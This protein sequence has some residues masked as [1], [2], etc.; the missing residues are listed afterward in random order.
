MYIPLAAEAERNGDEVAFA[1]AVSN[2]CYEFH[3][4]QIYVA[5]PVMAT[6][7]ENGEVYLDADYELDFAVQYL[8]DQ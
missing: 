7:D 6:L 1:Y 3:D 2:L 4:G 5:Y 8:A